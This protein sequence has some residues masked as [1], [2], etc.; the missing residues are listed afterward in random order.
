MA[1]LSF[2]LFISDAHDSFWGAGLQTNQQF[3]QILKFDIKG[4]SA[5]RDPE[6]PWLPQMDSPGQDGGSCSRF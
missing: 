1:F 2:G 6:T 4:H 3:S 5:A